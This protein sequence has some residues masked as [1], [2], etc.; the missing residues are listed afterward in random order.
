LNVNGLYDSGEPTTTTDSNGAF[1]LT[2]TSDQINSYPVVVSAIA[3]TTIDQDLPNTKLTSNMTMIAPAGSSSVVSPLTTL[4]YAKMATGL[5]LGS[6]KIAVQSEL[7]LTNLDVMKDYVFEKTTDCAYWDAHRLSASVAQVLKNISAQSSSTTPLSSK[8]NSISA[9]VATA[10][11]PIAKQ[12]KSTG[13]V[14]T[15]CAGSI[16][17]A[18]TSVDDQIVSAVN[19]YSIGGSISGLSGS[20]LVLT[21]GASSISLSAGSTSFTFPTLIATNGSYSVTISQNPADQKCTILNNSGTVVAQ[22]VTNIVV[23]CGSAYTYTVSTIAGSGNYGFAN[24]IGIAASFATPWGIATDAI[25]NL[26]IA[27]TFNHQIRK[28]TSSGVVTTFAGSTNGISGV[29]DGAIATATFIFPHG[30]ASDAS[31]NIFVAQPTSIRRITPQGV[32]STF[33]GSTSEVSGGADG[34]G[35]AATF[36]NP[37]GLAIDS[38]NTIYVADILNNNIRKITSTGVV[39]TFAGSKSGANGRADG[40]GTTATF[41]NPTAIAIDSSSNLFVA[42]QFNNTI[43]KITPAG[44]V[45]TFAGSTIS[46]SID[47]VGT[48]A[49]FNWPSGIAIDSNDNL[50]ISE[51]KNNLI[52]KIT[53]SAVVTTIVGKTTSGSKDGV[54]TTALLNGPV[55]ITKDSAGNLYFSDYGNNLIRKVTITVN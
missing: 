12:I 25:G 19:S 53:P 35:T 18:R 39:T 26:Y 3:G 6:A 20:G 10:V 22:S 2:A 44:V 17:T 1:T 50:Y 15:K 32:V 41:N 7:G 34:I 24:G 29:T 33:A 52:R 23:K 5:S 27:D 43:R 40:S 51:Y 9:Q 45:T 11:V 28:I 36:A 38:S 16:D 37:F 8:L 14:E 55:G 49:S 30:I 4:V 31:G 42:D 48:A 54:G 13:S 46:G 21:N 47:G